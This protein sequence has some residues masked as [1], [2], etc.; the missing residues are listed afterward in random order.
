MHPASPAPTI[1]ILGPSGTLP[2]SDTSDFLGE[3]VVG[4]VSLLEEELNKDFTLSLMLPLLFGGDDAAVE[5]T[6]E[7]TTDIYR[8]DHTPSALAESRTSVVLT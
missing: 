1:Q 3:S 2:V 6:E 8:S 5:D 7:E 4:E